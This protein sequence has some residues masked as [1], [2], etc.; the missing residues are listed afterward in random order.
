MT[1]YKLAVDTGG[2]F[3]DF[4]LLPD[5]GGPVFIAKV[6]TTPQNPALA[7]EEGL[8]RI[9]HLFGADRADITL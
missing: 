1:R 9:I 2:T 3:T 7:I 8:S 4:C 6:P 5:N